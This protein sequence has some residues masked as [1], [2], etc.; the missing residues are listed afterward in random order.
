MQPKGE[1]VCFSSQLEDTVHLSGEVRASLAWIMSSA[2]REQFMQLL[3][4]LSPFIV[5]K[6]TFSLQLT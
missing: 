2:Q 3:N 5:R 6:Q 4:A 1:K